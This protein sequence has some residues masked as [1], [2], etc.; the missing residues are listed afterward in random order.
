MLARV[1]RRPLDS[2]DVLTPKTVRDFA[3]STSM[4]P[5]ANGA[6]ADLQCVPRPLMPEQAP[7]ANRSLTE[8]AWSV[9]ISAS[10][11][12]PVA[13]LTGRSVRALCVLGAC[14]SIRRV[15]VSSAHEDVR[16]PL[17]VTIGADVCSSL[18]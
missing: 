7:P 16:L 3:S 8:S 17:D 13:S 10:P 6:H 9:D 12:R 5:R 15:A 1:D 4:P 18:V 2:A 11:C 14:A